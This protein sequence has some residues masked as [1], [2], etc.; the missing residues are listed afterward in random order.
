MFFVYEKILCCPL[1][2][3]E[4]II[5]TFGFE[6]VTM[7]YDTILISI[8]ILASYHQAFMALGH[9]KPGV[10]EQNYMYFRLTGPSPVHSSSQCYTWSLYISRSVHSSSKCCTWSLY[11]SRSVHSSSQCCTWSLYISRSVHSSSQCC[12]WS[13]YISRSV[14]SSSQ[15]CTWSLY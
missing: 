15:C 6:I 5:F 10:S 14:H 2:M 13:L 8:V 7:Q 11:I 12:T 4:L 1:I 3:D 9:N